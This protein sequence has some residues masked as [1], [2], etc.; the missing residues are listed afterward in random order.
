ML[1]RRLLPCD[2]SISS[3][4]DTNVARNQS[5][6]SP[7]AVVVAL[8]VELNN[9]ADGERM[10]LE[11]RQK[12]I[13]VQEEIPC[14]AIGVDE[15]PTVLKGTDVAAH[16]KSQAIC[17]ARHNTGCDL[18]GD[19]TASIIKSHIKLNCLIRMQQGG[20]AMDW[21]PSRKYVVAVHEQV[22]IEGSRVQ[23][24]PPLSEASYIATMPLPN[25][26]IRGA[27]QHRLDE[28]GVWSMMLIRL[29]IELDLLTLL[30]GMLLELWHHPIHSKEEISL[31]S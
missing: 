9:G 21:I 1:W 7:L 8:H 26:L 29:H 14:E 28:H 22:A 27:T 10:A 2:S 30:K 16:S 13:F 11:L 3:L 17:C 5:V 24:A 4:N 15:S 31:K 6:G 20:I 23:E 19:S 12:T 25:A 18:F